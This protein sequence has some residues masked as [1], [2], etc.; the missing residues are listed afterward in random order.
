GGLPGR[1]RPARHL[2]RRDR[3]WAGFARVR[4]AAPALVRG[5][6]RL[7]RLNHLVALD[8]DPGEVGYNRAA[9]RGT[10]SPRLGLRAPTRCARPCPGIPE[11]GPPPP[12]TTRAP[13]RRSTT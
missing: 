10:P 5:G 13:R 8:G 11:D 4:R 2:P 1:S 12:R 3:A 7:R 9:A 6:A